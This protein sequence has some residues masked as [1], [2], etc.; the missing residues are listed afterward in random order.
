MLSNYVDISFQGQGARPE[1][2]WM[3]GRLLGRVH[4]FLARHG[5]RDVAIALPRIQVEREQNGAGPGPGGVLRLH[6]TAERLAELVEAIDLDWFRRAGAVEFTKPRAVPVTDEF[7]CFRRGRAAERGSARQVAKRTDRLIRRL[8]AKGIEPDPAL[9]KDMRERLR[10]KRRVDR[11]FV[12]LESSETGQ[13][14]PLVVEFEPVSEACA[15]SFSSYG[16]SIGGATVP[17][18]L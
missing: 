15:G 4:G 16:L 8:E 13:R 17:F 3:L 18:F 14:F 12:N 1:S 7:A 5:Y 11:V 2:G 9:I 6:G 10:M